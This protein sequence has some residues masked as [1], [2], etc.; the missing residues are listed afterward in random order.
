MHSRLRTLTPW[1]A[2]GVLGSALLAWLGLVGY[3]WSDYD[4]EAAPAY[5]VLVRGDV[6][7]FFQHLP[8]YGGSLIMRAPFALAASAFGGGDVAVFRAV[9]VP[10][11]LAGA[12]LGVVLAASLLAR[13]AGRGTAAIAVGVCAANPITLRALDVGHPEE[14]LGA[15]LCVGAVLAAVR[16]RST[17]AGVLLGLALANK[18]WALLAIGP[19]LLALQ[20]DRRRAL[21][22]AGGIAVAFMLP[23]LLAGASTPSAAAAHTGVIFQPWQVWWFTGATGEVIRG[24]SGM[25]KEGYRAA[26]DWLSPI[27]H[28]LIVLMAV[29]L[30]LLAWRRRSDPLLLLVLL[31]VLRCVL[32]PWNT[33]YYVLPAILALVAWE[34]TRFVDRPPVLALSLTMATWAMWEWVVP[35]ASADVESLVY[36]AWSLPLV[37]FLGWRLYTPALPAMPTLSSGGRASVWSTTQ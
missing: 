21:L 18:A 27:S 20:A 14:L 11:L 4:T 22:I 2:F 33:A 3:Y 25:V 13:G 9:S 16:G 8:A 35:I 5:A 29:P 36:L 31:F 23:L 1:I 7:S 26:P 6:G 19:V 15:A 37:G 17:L 24:S 34:A 28:P 30:S 10:C 12:A 32:D